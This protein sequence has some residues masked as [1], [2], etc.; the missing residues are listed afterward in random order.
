[1]AFP[2]LLSGLAPGDAGGEVSKSLP[3]P[4]VAGGGLCL[5]PRES[6][7]GVSSVSSLTLTFCSFVT[8]GDKTPGSWPG[9]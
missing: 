7:D 5:P 8:G 6:E 9:G 1:M 3:F 4:L 2:L